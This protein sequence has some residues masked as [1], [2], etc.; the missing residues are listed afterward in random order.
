MPDR[1][2]GSVNATFD[3]LANANRDRRERQVILESIVTTTNVDGS[4]NI[5]PMGPRVDESLDAFQIRPFDTSKT[6]ANLKRTRYGVM[7]VIDNVEM[8]ARAAIG[9]LETL[10]EFVSPREVDGFVIADCC[11]WYEF[12]VEY[13]D[14]TGP[15]MDLNCR[16]VATGRRRDFWGFNRAKHAVLEAAILA[17]R[18]DFLPADEIREQFK[19]L[20]TIVQKTG[21]RQETDAFELLCQF[22]GHDQ[23]NPARA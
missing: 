6:F 12:K 14:E 23:G 1:K 3:S 4:P 2:T 7:H 17:T 10:P 19:R 15:R 22:V 20:E 13:I 11:R 16:T 21:G 9:K 8:F 18:I 5:S